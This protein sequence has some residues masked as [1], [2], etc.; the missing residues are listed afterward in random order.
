MWVSGIVQPTLG[1]ATHGSFA[2]AAPHQLS[3][4]R[5]R[6]IS[7]LELLGEA[8]CMGSPPIKR[9]GVQGSPPIKRRGWPSCDDDPKPIAISWA[10]RWIC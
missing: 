5:P 1:P 10:A 4:P 3:S 9:G 2:A 8:G 7:H 6:P